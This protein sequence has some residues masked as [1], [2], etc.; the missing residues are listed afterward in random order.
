MKKKT[1]TV[2]DLHELR[3]IVSKIAQLY[4][5]CSNVSPL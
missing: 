2:L 1:I 5:V 4:C 3:I